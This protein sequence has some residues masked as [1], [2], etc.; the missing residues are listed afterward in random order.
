MAE[1]KAA[2]SEGPEG[3]RADRPTEEPTGAA[4]ETAGEPADEAVAE[5]V[6]CW[7]DVMVPDLA[8][9]K[10]FYGELFAW[11]FD[12]AGPA[13]QG[14][15]TVARLGRRRAAGLMRK[16]DGRM[17]TVWT[18]YLATADVGATTER[19]RAA[20]GQVINDP[21][22]VGSGPAGIMAVAADPDGAVF[23]LWQPAERSGFEVR[24]EPGAYVWAE[25]HTREPAGVDAFYPDVFGYRPLDPADVRDAG[26]REEEP[27]MVVWVPRSG[28]A[29]ESAAVTARCLL[30]EGTPPELPAHFLTYFA[31]EDCDAAAGTVE[32][33]GGRVRREPESG[34]YGRWAVCRDNQGATFAVLAPPERPAQ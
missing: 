6:P 30:E 26:G 13:A 12:E 19:V 14:A 24:E 21:R 11:T 33:L 4:T 8:A 2:P 23:G 3:T 1:A 5:G 17:P 9:A 29:D 20:G 18:V 31:V 27:E 7:A 32:R 22:P 10:R 15:Y 34:P 28:P 25:V 16:T